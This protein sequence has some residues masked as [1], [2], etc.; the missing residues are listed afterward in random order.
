M[1]Y[2]NLV[3]LKVVLL[4]DEFSNTAIIES[5]LSESFSI[6]TRCFVMTIREFEMLLYFHH[7]EPEKRDEILKIIGNGLEGLGERKSFGSVYDELKLYDNPH[8]KG[9]MDYAKKMLKMFSD[10]L[11]ESDRRE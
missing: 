3:T 10:Q 7:N 4:Y 8:M 2:S 11:I 9:E 6:K 5:A 1:R